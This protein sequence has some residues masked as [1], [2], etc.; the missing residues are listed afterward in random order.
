LFFLNSGVFLTTEGSP[1]LEELSQLAAE[2]VEIFSC[3]TCL[4]YYNL[5][6]KLRV[7]QV[8]NMYDSVESMQSATK[9]IVV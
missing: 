4:D 1:V 6:D 5:K 8:T 9:C 3:G 7:G 2:G